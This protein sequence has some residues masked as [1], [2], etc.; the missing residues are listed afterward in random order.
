M[1]QWAE[2]KRRSPNASMICIDIQPYASTQA[3]DRPGVF[4][5]GG[6]S[7]RVFDLIGAVAGGRA[8]PGLWVRRIRETRLESEARGGEA[9][10][11]Q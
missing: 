8:E 9:D 6:F 11:R 10:T 2:F 3:K 7:D 4:N 5:V 1:K